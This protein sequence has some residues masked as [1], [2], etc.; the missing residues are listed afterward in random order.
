MD[1]FLY[2]FKGINAKKL[3]KSL[4]DFDTLMFKSQSIFFLIIREK[5]SNLMLIVNNMKF[6]CIYM[7]GFR[8]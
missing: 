1:K 2:L 5:I 7:L 4:V 3:I 6:L 8:C